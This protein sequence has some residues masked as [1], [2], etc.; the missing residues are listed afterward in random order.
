MYYWE[1]C[2]GKIWAVNG[3]R[4]IWD[5]GS[6]LGYDKGFKSIF[7]HFIRSG[8]VCYECIL[9]IGSSHVA[10]Q[11]TRAKWWLKNRGLVNLAPK[12][13]SQKCDW[14]KAPP[15]FVNVTLPPNLKQNEHRLCS[16][17]L[18]VCKA[19]LLLL[20]Y[21]AGKTPHSPHPPQKRSFGMEWFPNVLWQFFVWFLSSW[22][23]KA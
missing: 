21:A 7:P 6:R 5:A 19:A 16:K 10:L 8:T 3:S 17:S 23:S 4:G 15:F 1:R 9:T 22:L 11:E 13:S 12:I 2:K 18:W 14:S 20:H